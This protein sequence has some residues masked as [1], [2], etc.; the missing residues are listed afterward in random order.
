M[1]QADDV[2]TKQDA[3][4]SVTALVDILKNMPGIDRA[5]ACQLEGAVAKWPEMC[6]AEVLFRFSHVKHAVD[7]FI[8][9]TMIRRMKPDPQL[10]DPDKPPKHGQRIAFGMNLN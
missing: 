6:E 9:A 7:R 2:R 4:E 1:R 10:P 5:A 8:Q 3:I